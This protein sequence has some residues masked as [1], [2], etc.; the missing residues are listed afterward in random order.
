MGFLS[1]FSATEMPLAFEV[2]AQSDQNNEVCPS[3]LTFRLAAGAAAAG[4]AGCDANG[5]MRAGESLAVRLT[6]VEIS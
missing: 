3:S 4:G 5:A 1:G 6:A 2:I